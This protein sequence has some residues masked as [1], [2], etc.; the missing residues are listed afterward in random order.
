MWVCESLKIFPPIVQEVAGDVTGGQPP[1][2]PPQ[3]L[4][5][6]DGQLT[7]LQGQPMSMSSEPTVL[8]TTRSGM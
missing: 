1:S 3:L 5:N 7:S 2:M 4:A 8:V 6:M